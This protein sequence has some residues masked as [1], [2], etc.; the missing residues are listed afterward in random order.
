MSGVMRSEAGWVQDAPSDTSAGRGVSACTRGSQLLNDHAAAVWWIGRRS[1]V[2]SEPEGSVRQ[3]VDPDAVAM[4]VDDVEKVGFELD[5]LGGLTDDLED[6]LLDAMANA[7]AE[8]CDATK[9][10]LPLAV[11]G[12]DVVGDQ[13]LHQATVQGT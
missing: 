13:Q 9:S 7:L 4:P 10:A 2:L 8:F 11:G 3:P 1:E 5:L 6:G 12:T